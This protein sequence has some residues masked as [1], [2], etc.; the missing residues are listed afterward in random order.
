MN[1]RPASNLFRP[2]SCRPQNELGI[3]AHGRRPP[4]HQPFSGGAA[5]FSFDSVSRNLDDSGYY[6]SVSEQNENEGDQFV[7]VNRSDA[8]R[9]P[10]VMGNEGQGAARSVDPPAAANPDFDVNFANPLITSTAVLYEQLMFDCDYNV[11]PIHSRQSRC[12][13]G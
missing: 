5:Q 8:V 13:S 11:R 6:S 9:P 2:R 4:S 3:G 7:P 10:S 1:P 12:L